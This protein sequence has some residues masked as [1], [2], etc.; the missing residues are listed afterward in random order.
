M[1]GRNSWRRRRWSMNLGNGCM[2]I[3]PARS[4]VPSNCRKRWLMRKKLLAAAQDFGYG[5]FNGY[6]NTQAKATGFFRVEQVNDVWWF[7]DPE[8]H[9]FLSTSSNGIGGRG[10]RGG[11][12]GSGTSAPTTQPVTAESHQSAAG[13]LG[14]DDRR[15][16]P[17]SYRVFE[18][19]AQRPNDISGSARC[20]CRGFCLRHRSIGEY[21]MHAAQERSS[22]H[23]LFH[24]Q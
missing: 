4:K 9:F 20:L 16:R 7:V 24:W 8:G 10:G 6:L 18:L 21:A 13:F 17:A 3:G 14:P 5:K 22:P 15:H 1:R 12:S 23:R 2:R 11:R 19:A